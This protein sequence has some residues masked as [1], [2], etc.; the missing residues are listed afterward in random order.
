VYNTSLLGKD[1]EIGNVDVNLAER[2][3]FENLPLQPSVT[4]CFSRLQ[5]NRASSLFHFSHITV[6]NSS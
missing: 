6:Q 4:A 3:S 2:S 5:L 1:S